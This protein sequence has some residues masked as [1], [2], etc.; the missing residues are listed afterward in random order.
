DDWNRIL[1]YLDDLY[2]D[3]TVYCSKSASFLAGSFF[4][5]TAG[6][7]AGISADGFFIE[8]SSV[9]YSSKALKYPRSYSPW[10]S[11]AAKSPNSFLSW[12][13]DSS[14]RV[15]SILGR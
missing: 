5:P 12:L 3:S 4:S 13:I 10:I 14:P 8:D 9:T 11:L 1:C 15:P 2:D 6:G 7:V